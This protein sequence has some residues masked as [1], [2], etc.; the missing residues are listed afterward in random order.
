MKDNI[1]NTSL[2][3]VIV[4]LSLFTIWVVFSNT[5]KNHQLQKVNSVKIEEMNKKVDSLE[6]EIFIHST[7]VTR[8]EIALNRL[9]ELDSV[10][11]QKFE[12]ALSNIE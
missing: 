2:R 3:G 7:N 9:K 8:Y 5:K 1:T 6:N 10:S 12:D 4:I 11:A